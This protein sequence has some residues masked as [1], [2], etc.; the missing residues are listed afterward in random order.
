MSVQIKTPTKHLFERQEF[1]YGD[2]TKKVPE[3][4]A[5][6]PEDNGKDER[7]KQLIRE[8]SATW[9]GGRGRKRRAS[10]RASGQD[11][12]N[13]RKRF[14]RYGPRHSKIVLPTKFL[15][16]GNIS[17]P[18]NLNSMCDEEINRALN[19]KTPDSSPLPMPFKRHMV[20]VIIPANLSDPL[21][22]NAGD[23]YDDTLLVSPRAKRKRSKYRHKKK[24]AGD[25]DDEKSSEPTSSALESRRRSQERKMLDA[26]VSPV[27]PQ[28]LPKKRRKRTSSEGVN[29][30]DQE[31]DKI[32]PQKSQKIKCHRQSSGNTSFS[33]AQKARLQKAQRKN[34]K[35]KIYEYGNY[36]SYYQ[37]PNIAKIEDKRFS[38]FK[39]N[40][41]EGRDVLDI[42]C[43]VG[44]VTL[45][46]ARDFHPRR[47][48]GLDIDGD[49]IRLAKKNVRHYISRETTGANKFPSAMGR[50]Y[51]PIVGPPVN[52]KHLHTSTKRSKNRSYLDNVS[53]IQVC[54]L[55]KLI[56]KADMSH[57]SVTAW[58]KRGNYCN[59][60]IRLQY[61]TIINDYQGWGQVQYLYLS[62][63]LSVLDVLGVWKCQSTCT[64]T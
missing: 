22:L 36:H 35:K 46:I 2:K 55:P 48:I 63:Y 53:F 25:E 21:N 29:K 15:L 43:N 26:I 61:I 45:S 62:T 37:T 59:F 1:Q 3:G 8:R 42:G 51:G 24:S 64:C 6:S 27:I 60:L 49:L 9:G 7:K 11:N 12:R 52:K 58:H 57:V 56:W 40:W 19:E 47:I 13:S 50:M 41:F 33:S 14:C 31:D 54:T 30:S 17:D 44:H 39:R 28:D 38:Y 23:D 5:S 4:A 34:K 16:G 18:L 10:E 32:S 20:E